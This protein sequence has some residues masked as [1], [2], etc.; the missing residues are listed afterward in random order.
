MPRPLHVP[1]AGAM[2]CLARDV[3]VR[4]AGFIPIRGGD[5]A[6][7]EVGGVTVRAHEVPVL[8]PTGPVQHV[9]GTDRA[10]GIQLIP[11]LSS[12]RL[13]RIPS[14]PKR[15]QASAWQLQQ[16]LLQRINTE[17]VSDIE[18]ADDPIR[19]VGADNVFSIVTRKR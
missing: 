10:V 8:G 18:V 11:A 13:P 19:A 14:K 9:A 17:R 6:L 1:G 4:P 15:L 12:G 2:A 3:D 7:P 5:V 16:V